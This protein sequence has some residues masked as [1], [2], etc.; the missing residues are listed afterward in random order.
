VGGTVSKRMLTTFVIEAQASPEKAFDYLVDVTK[1]SDWSPHPFR[2]DPPPALPITEG[3][4]FVS[5]GRVPGDK[6]HTNRV[7]VTELDPP[8]LLVLTS[9]DRGEEFIHRF[10]VAATAHGCRVSRTVD[11]PKPT[12][13]LG[14]TFPV[15]FA[16]VI[17]PDVNKGM[18]LL[19]R[20]LNTL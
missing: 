12:G 9:E 5:H 17:K 8:R 6:D 4:T 18:E 15:I 20:Q 10:E 11:S 3:S 1:H 19:R 7:T 14:V 13:L 2:I 16:L